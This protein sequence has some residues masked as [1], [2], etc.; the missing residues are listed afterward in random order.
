MSERI[1]I[2]RVVEAQRYLL[3]F[4]V[5]PWIA[6]HPDQLRAALEDQARFEFWFREELNPRPWTYSG[7]LKGW[8]EH[9]DTLMRERHE[10]LSEASKP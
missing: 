1:D 3:G 10:L 7:D 6:I 4:L 8:R 5:N 2:D 9:I